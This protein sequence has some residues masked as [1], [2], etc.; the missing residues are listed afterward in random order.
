[1]EARDAGS[2]LALWIVGPGAVEIR[3]AALRAA[4]GDVLLA[5]RFSGISRGT[6]A[7]VLRGGVP[8]GE[9]TRMRAPLQAG[10]FP[11]PVKYGYAAVGR[12]LEGAEAGR[13]A[14]VLAPHQDRLAVPG[15][16]VLP[17]PE[18]VPAGR[19]V[20]AANMETAL[21]VV[22]DGAAGPGDRVAVIG[23]GVVGALAA[24]LCGRMP[25]AEV[26][27][28]DLLPG[29]A[30]L[31]AA[32]G[33]GFALPEDAPGGCDLV[34]HASAS[35]AGLETALAAAGEEARVVEASWYGDRAGTLGLGGGFHSRRLR[36]VSSQVGMV[37]ASRRA[38]WPRRRR[39]E[40][41]LRLLADPALD[42]LISGETDFSDLPARYGAILDDPGT[43]CHRIA[44][45]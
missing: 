32:L 22:W 4:P 2:A 39:L 1:M 28:I 14:F 17:L 16:M 44:Y 7:L 10:D 3:G 45:R 18:G 24:W 42:A 9:R 5:T 41:A 29:R 43:L 26:T 23:A 36:L 8:E 27:L 40:A 19:A 31:A 20:L 37:P 21:N 34:I 33:V 25:G 35:A 13:D 30:A 38:R 15:A 12:I 6:E 11:W